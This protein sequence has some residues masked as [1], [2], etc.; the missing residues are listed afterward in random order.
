MLVRGFEDNAES[1]VR[2]YGG[3]LDIRPPY[4]REFV[5]KEEQRN[6]VIDTVMKGF[7]LNVFYWVKN[8][9]DDFEL[10]DGQQRTISICQYLNGDYSVNSLYFYNLPDDKQ[11]QILNY[12]L[13]RVKYHILFFFPFRHPL[14]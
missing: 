4:Q 10:L 9:D 2:A 8:E 11:E 12:E 3:R 5:Y 1:G 13:L 7:P 6:K 14:L